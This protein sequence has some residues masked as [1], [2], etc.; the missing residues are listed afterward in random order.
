MVHEAV[1]RRAFLGGGAMLG[2]GLALGRHGLDRVSRPPASELRRRVRQPG[3]RPFPKLPEGADTLPQI[4]HVVVVM[5]ENHSYDNYLGMLRRGDGFRL[6]DDGRPA[7]ALPDGK[8]NL[9]RAFHMPSTCQLDAVPSQ[10]WNASHISLGDDDNDGF[11]R[12]CGPVAMGYWTGHDIP[13]YYGLARR[14]PVCDR[15]F[16]SCLAQTYPNRRFLYAGTA[17]GIVSTTNEALVAPP[18][19]NGT[20]FERLDAHG[21]PWL[22]YASDAPQL[23]ILASMFGAF[24]GHIAKI[25]RFYADARAGTLPFLSLVDPPFGA[26]GSEENPQDIRVGEAFVAKVVRAVL[27][28]PAWPKTVLIWC[29][30]EH[31]GYYDHVVPPRAIPPDSIPPAI[32]VPPDL[33]GGYDR[34]GFRVPAVIV[35]PYAR[36][37]YVSHVLHDHTSILKL[38]ETKWNLPA[39]TFR[40][41]NA[42]NLLDSLDLD[43]RRPA[44]LDPPDLP[45]PARA[46][47]GG[48]PAC[49]PGHPGGPIPPA[50]AVMPA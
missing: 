44:F 47:A 35:S 12:A 41:A 24:S 10:A 26:E 8:G 50:S 19:P 13:F 42:D 40:D 45:A 29:Y 16:G 30:D 22:D 9:V 21:V 5:M 3:S 33:P 34:Y 46:G 20:I 1:S 38:I 28:S 2:A 36:K 37:H 31:G 14:F 48:A 49:T 39:L 11:V 6:D 27:D 18:P 43:A 17:A 25:D 23:A 32:H 4:E 15:W 7:V